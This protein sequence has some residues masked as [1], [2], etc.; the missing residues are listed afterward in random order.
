[1]RINVPAYIVGFIVVFA[2]GVYLLTTFG[3]PLISE[4]SLDNSTI[5]Y[6]DLARQATIKRDYVKAETMYKE[7]ISSAEK[8][9]PKG[10]ATAYALVTYADFLRS[11]KRPTEAAAFEARARDLE[12]Q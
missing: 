12:H 7:A 3:K 5:G 4:A 9:S 6:I 8:V 1:M 11:R 2:V 10:S